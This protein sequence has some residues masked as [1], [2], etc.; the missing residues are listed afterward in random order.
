ML[1]KRESMKENNKYYLT[2]LGLFELE[3]SKEQFMEAER[4][5]G[6]YPKEDGEL[7]TGGFGF[8]KNGFQ[9]KGRIEY[10]K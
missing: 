8:E 6:F 1:N 3:V 5:C 10:A 9:C 4:L 2:M 7:A